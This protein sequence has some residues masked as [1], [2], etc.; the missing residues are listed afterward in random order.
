MRETDKK[1]HEGQREDESEE[2]VVLV[3]GCDGR[4]SL[5]THEQGAGIVRFE[6]DP[7]AFHNSILPEWPVLQLS[8]LCTQLLAVLDLFI[9]RGVPGSF[10]A[11]RIRLAEDDE[12]VLDGKACTGLCAHGQNDDRSFQA[13][14]SSG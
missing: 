3:T 9:G 13:V 11:D 4:F 8:H 14:G 12:L 1:D 2:I 7:V 5:K 6:L 10:L